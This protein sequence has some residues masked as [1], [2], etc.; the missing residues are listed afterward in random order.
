MVKTYTLST[1]EQIVQIGKTLSKSWFRGHAQVYGNLQ[2]KIYREHY[3]FIREFRPIIEGDIIYN[4]QRQAPTFLTEIPKND[5]E[6][7]FLMQHHGAPTRLL[8]WSESVLVATYFAVSK[9]SDKDGELWA[10]LPWELNKKS[11]G[12]YG[13]PTPDD[14][15]YKKLVSDAFNIVLGNEI[16]DKDPAAE[17]PLAVQ[18]PLSFPRLVNQLST[19]TIHPLPN[20]QN[21]ITNLLSE[22]EHLVRY[23]IPSNRKDNIL[24]HLSLLGIKRHTL[25]PDLDSLCADLINEHNVVGYGPPQPP[26]C[27]GE[28]NPKK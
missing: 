8:D 2:P 25:F 23:I 6:W 16:K 17:Y 20:N 5:S 12:F 27:D 22:P 14:V 21:Q 13:I 28:Y 15:S 11:G 3:N 10:M 1:I 7:L 19:F 4:F 24:N 26:Q 18:P 9:H